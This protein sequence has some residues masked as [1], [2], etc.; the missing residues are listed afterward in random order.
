MY[1]LQCYL[2][3]EEH[4][5]A[6]YIP[7]AVNLKQTRELCW[8]SS[9]FSLIDTGGKDM[10]NLSMQRLLPAEDKKASSERCNRLL[11]F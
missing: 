1:P 2:L 3:V 10:H 8:Q 6:L 9:Y 5:D 4:A 11:Q 7:S